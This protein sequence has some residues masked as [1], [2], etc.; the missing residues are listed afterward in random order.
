[1]TRELFLHSLFE[2]LGWLAAIAA[3]WQI[4]RR[5]LADQRL[6]MPMRDY[7][8]YMIAVWVGALG[9]AIALGT[10]NLSLAGLPGLGRSIVG[11]LVGGVIVAEIYKGIR[12]ISGSTGIVFV[13]PLALAIAIGRVGCFFGGLP[14]FTYGTPTALP[15]GVDFGDGLPRHPVQLYESAAMAAFLAG[16]LWLMV[17][18]R[19][20]AIRNG[21]Y[22]FALFY[23]VQRFAWEFLKPYPAL[24]GPFNLFHF[25]C[26]FLVLYAV[27]MLRIRESIHARS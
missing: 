7:P 5:Y 4:K 21:F 3:G 10:L 18:R 12:G 17:R 22:L 23:G 13:V 6:P 24:A 26:L 20:W 15:W 27:S 2:L 8:V 25:A 19:D 9:G 1:M 16:F 11:A 14:D